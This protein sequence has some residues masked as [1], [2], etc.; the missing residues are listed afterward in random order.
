MFSET[1]AVGSAKNQYMSLL[2]CAA[3]SS[4]ER[5]HQNLVKTKVNFAFF[6]KRT[7]FFLLKLESVVF[8][9]AAGSKYS[10]RFL[11]MFCYNSKPV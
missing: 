8:W 7:F 6:V 2:K 9:L 11:K 10:S 5:S 3:T 1:F 4:T